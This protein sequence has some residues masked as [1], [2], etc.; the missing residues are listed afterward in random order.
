[1]KIGDYQKELDTWLQQYEKPYWEPLSQLARLTEEVGELARV[2]NHKY[3]DKVKKASEDSDDLDGELGD[4]LITVI[5]LANQEGIDL[6]K[7]LQKVF[8]KMRT[9]DKDRYAK[10]GEA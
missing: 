1:M 3:G 6:E 10:K 4:I 7:A 2:L 5:F 9:R 8:T